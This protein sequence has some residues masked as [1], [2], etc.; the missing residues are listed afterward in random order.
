MKIKPIVYDTQGICLEYA[1]PGSGAGRTKE[2]DR[3]KEREKIKEALLPFIKETVRKQLKEERE[4][5]KSRPSLAA[6][7]ME[8]VF[9]TDRP[10]SAL[11]SGVALRVYEKVEERLRLDAMRKSR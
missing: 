11:V 8:Q 10:E 6:K 1:H 5:Y 4:Y 3:T 2:I 9:G 7:H